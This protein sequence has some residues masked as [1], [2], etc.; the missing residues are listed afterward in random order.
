[1][2]FDWCGEMP[3]KFLDDMLTAGLMFDQRGFCDLVFGNLSLSLFNVSWCV[4]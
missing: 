1:V 3:V 2:T 4:L